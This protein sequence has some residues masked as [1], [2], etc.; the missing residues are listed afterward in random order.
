VDAD[1]F[2]R[3]TKRAGRR[4]LARIERTAG[5]ADLAGM[6]RQVVVPDGQRKRR[7]VFAWIKKN[8][9]RRPARRGRCVVR[10]PALSRGRRCELP[11]RICTR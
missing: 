10:P 3:L 1:L 9:R 2:V 7:P 6:M 8:Q 4:V 11:L 5:K